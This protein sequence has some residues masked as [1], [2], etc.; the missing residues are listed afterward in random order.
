[1]TEVDK[2]VE[3]LVGGGIIIYPTD[4]IWGLGCDAT[5]EGA[6]DRIFEIKRRPKTKPF[7]IL[8]SSIDMLKKFVDDVHPRLETLLAYHQRPLTV[9]YRKPKNLPANVTGGSSTVAV[10]IAADLFCRE[11]I[12]AF[13]KPIVATSANFAGEPFPTHFGSISSE[14]IRKV[15][16]VAKY[17]QDELSPSE[18]SVIVKLTDKSELIF[19]RS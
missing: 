3:T 5:N 1:M 14:L 12:E 11:V 9:I 2:I 15:D 19:V 17:K 7:V 18:P 10:R 6:V 16:Y 8:V 4:T 13:G